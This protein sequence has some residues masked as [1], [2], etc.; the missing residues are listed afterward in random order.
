M[1]KYIKNLA[2]ILMLISAICG[3]PVFASDYDEELNNN[4][5]NHL[6]NWDTEF[7]IDYYNKDVIDVVRDIAKKD[8][9]LYVSLNGLVYKRYG[10]NATITATYRTTKEQEEYINTELTRVT[11]SIIIKDM[12]SFEKVKTINKYLVNRFEYD[13][14][15]VSNNAYSALTTG[16]TTCQGYALTASKM[17]NL[18]GIQNQ[19]IVGD[20][21]GVPHAWNLVNIDNRWYQLDITN[22]DSTNSDN[23][24]LK[25]DEILK[26]NGFTWDSSEY[27]KSD[28]NYD[29]T[30]NSLSNIKSGLSATNTI[31][32]G[33]SNGQQQP[34]TGFKSK[35][36]GNWILI[37]NLW[38][39][40]KDD[41]NYAT[42]WNIIDSNWYYLDNNGAMQTGWIYSGGKWYYCYP[43]SGAMA[44]NDVIGGYTVD[45][46]GAWVA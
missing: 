20:L 11:N 24:F 29:E 32:Q 5:Y 12:S 15:L 19:I 10:D 27:P 33:I 28:E 8:P 46:S 22:N 40:S 30:K 23:Y 1:K 37:N 34:A 9:Y 16:K 36:D 38:Y 13:Y 42:G 26:E 21:N 7:D 3:Q 17:F 43:V 25:D 39:F 45:S 4:V 44:M 31:T 18:A 6:E 35:V 14:S 41:G 2:L